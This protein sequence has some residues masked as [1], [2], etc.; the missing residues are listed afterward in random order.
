MVEMT[1]SSLLRLR[2]APRLLVVSA[3][4]LLGWLSLAPVTAQFLGSG[5]F[6]GAMVDFYRVPMS[7]EGGPVAMPPHPKWRTVGTVPLA[8]RQLGALQGRRGIEEPSRRPRVARTGTARGIC[9]LVDFADRVAAA[10][11]TWQHYIDMLFSLS[12]TYATGSMRDYYREVSYN[13]LDVQGAVANGATGGLA[14]W[15]R[16]PSNHAWYCNNAQG[17]GAY[18]QNAQKLVEDAI[19]AADPIVNFATYAPGGAGT[20]VELLFVVHA[21]TSSQ[22][23]GLNTDM[24]THKWV[25]SANQNVDGVFCRTYAFEAEDD[26][27]GAFAHEAAHVFGAPDLYDYDTTGFINVWD[28][29]DYPVEEWCLMASGSWGGPNL[30][31]T[32]PSHP[33]GYIRWLLGW[34]PT[35]T[36]LTTANGGQT[37]PVQAQETDNGPQAMYEYSLNAN[38]WLLIENRYPGAAGIRFD[39]YETNNFTVNQ[40]KRGGII[41]YHMD[42]REP[43]GT[44]RL[45]DAWPKNNNYYLWVEDPGMGPDPANPG[46]RTAANQYELKANAAFRSDGV[47]RLSKDNANNAIG[48]LPRRLYPTTRDFQYVFGN[49]EWID[50]NSV[51]ANT[52]YIRLQFTPV[53]ITFSTTTVGTTALSS[54]N[55]TQIAYSLWGVAQSTWLDDAT[56]AVTQADP[57]SVFLYNPM[58][59]GSGPAHAWAA[60]PPSQAGQIPGTAGTIDC[61]Y[62]EQWQPSCLLPNTDA[63]YS[64]SITARTLFGLPA[65]ASGLFGAWTGMC[66]DN[67]RLTFA[68][69]T[70][71]SPARPAVGQRSWMI[72]SAAGYQVMYD[73]QDPQVTISDPAVGDVNWGTPSHA[74]TGTASDD[75]GLQQVT[76]R[77]NGG[78]WNAATG[79]TSW[80]IGG[81]LQPGL[82]TI[83]ARAHDLA[84]KTKDA[85]VL[86][87]YDTARPST[88]MR[89]PTGTRAAFREASVLLQGTTRDDCTLKAVRLRV[90]SGVWQTIHQGP[91]YPKHR[92]WRKRVTLAAG[93]NEVSIKAVDQAAHARTDRLT[94]YYDTQRP[95]LAITT[96]NSGAHRSQASCLVK[97]TASDAVGL[98]SVRVRVGSGAWQ[99]AWSGQ[100]R[101][102]LTWQS[103]V[104][105]SEGR[106]AITAM[107]RDMSGRT[108]SQSVTVWLDSAAARS[109]AQPL[110]LLGAS[111]Q[112]LP[113][114]SVSCL[115]RLSAEARV[116]AEVVNL[117]GR[118]V[119][120]LARDLPCAPGTHALLWSGRAA[121]GARAPGGRYLVRL[122]AA[123]PTGERA[124]ALTSVVLTGP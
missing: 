39:Q 53:N 120:L 52:M 44:G 103:T 90:G 102:S 74:V 96:P 69:Q 66:D 19:A 46:T 124:Q 97:G 61:K 14:G 99:S 50:I 67:T 21:G 105:L 80:T 58:S 32:N 91:P 77:I 23:S 98:R 25:T 95:S 121:S 17:L 13:L 101:K 123:G 43:S 38:E 110:V 34:I 42:L 122:E 83:E 76:V 16:M 106:N 82:N 87:Y 94:L 62:Y 27:I 84:G 48:G 35:V 117:A 86:C 12:P 116:R 119:A 6:H 88:T 107:A 24:A 75:A 71:G 5:P 33:C 68:K 93:V 20:E 60:N 65:L 31:G 9:L 18:P 45:N 30:D 10:P 15:F 55:W 70:T 28:D 85:S 49:L 111:A 118:P 22:S 3:V 104:T 1:R 100:W 40:A 114:G 4:A 36:Q 41:I 64:T 29:N 54:P 51:P 47:S 26:A 115:F 89:S 59:S 92:R 8:I 56:P 7:A 109:I 112:P 113:N 108:F 57:G 2:V 73:A 72:T 81:T 63:T 78:T 11:W 37:I 79:T